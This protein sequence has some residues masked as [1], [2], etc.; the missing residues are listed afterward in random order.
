[1]SEFGIAVGIAQ[2]VCDSGSSHHPVPCGGINPTTHPAQSPVGARQ[3]SELV[4]STVDR[5]QSVY[6]QPIR[7]AVAVR[8]STSDLQRS[9]AVVILDNRVQSRGVTRNGFIV[10]MAPGP[11][12]DTVTLFI[13][14]LF[15]NEW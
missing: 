4:S 8:H 14:V 10:T 5:S 13:V 2:S 11:I 1:M 6:R 7:A 3:I 15:R 12:L 9:G